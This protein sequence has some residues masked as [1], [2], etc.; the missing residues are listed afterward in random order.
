[1]KLASILFFLLFCLGVNAQKGDFLSAVVYPQQ[2]AI[3]NSYDLQWG[4]NDGLG[5]NFTQLPT[6]SVGFGLNY[7]HVETDY[8]GWRTGIH[9]S[10]QGQR[11]SGTVYPMNDSDSVF[12]NS[13][14]RLSYIKIPLILHFN[15]S[16]TE[17]DR[18]YF[19]LGYGFQ[20]SFLT[21][22]NV[23]VDTEPIPYAF[24]PDYNLG[25]FYDFVN[26]SFLLT[27]D[28]HIRLGEKKRYYLLLGV[29]FDK[30]IGGIENEKFDFT[31]EDP[32]EWKYPFGTLKDEGYAV[33]S[34]RMRYMS[35]NETFSIRVGLN[36]RLG[37]QK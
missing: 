8:I 30:T 19:S 24:N 2:V 17:D 6:Y 3:K 23:E 31:Q 13:H 22:G 28:L 32:E 7:Y 20:L 34:T 12:Y 21:G 10:Q 18:V 4:G 9:Y 36:I 15:I 1:M 29:K 35:K 25:V 14:L 26:P 5:Q 11:Y 16:A 27:G 37:E 33:Q